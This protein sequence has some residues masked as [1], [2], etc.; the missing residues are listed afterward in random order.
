MTRQIEN[1]GDPEE[2]LAGLRSKG[3]ANFQMT[4]GLSQDSFGR[5][6]DTTETVKGMPPVVPRGVQLL[7]AG[8]CVVIGCA[9][10]AYFKPVETQYVVAPALP[11]ASSAQLTPAPKVTVTKTVNQMPEA[12]TRALKAAAKVLD[13]AADTASASDKQLDIL[14][15]A[16]QAI[17]DR[18]WR[19]LNTVADKQ[20]ELERTLSAPNAKFLPGYL[21]LKR[22]IESCLSKQ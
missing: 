7:V 19:K 16:Y 12:C 6:G 15:E 3:P 20:R 5:S 10:G 22:D 1:P 21:D 8:A 9:I 11:P 2:Y 13:A 17:L 14:S 18:D 4:D